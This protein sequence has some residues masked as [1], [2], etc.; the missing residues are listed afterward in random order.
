VADGGRV[1][2][3]RYA[4]D[5]TNKYVYIDAYRDSSAA[6]YTMAVIDEITRRQAGAGENAG[7]WALPEGIDLRGSAHQLQV[8]GE[9]GESDRFG[10]GQQAAAAVGALALYTSLTAAEQGAALVIPGPEVVL[11]K[12]FAKVKGFKFIKGAGRWVMQKVVRRGGAE[13]VEAVAESEAKALYQEFKA[14]RANA[15][16][17]EGTAKTRQRN[18]LRRQYMGQNPKTNSPTYRSVVERMRAAGKIV[19]EGADAKVLASDGTWIPLDEADLSHTKDAMKY[20]NETGKYWGERHPKVREFMLD[21]GN[22]VLDKPGPNRSAGA[23][24]KGAGYDPPAPRP[25]GPP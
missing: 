12:A 2:D 15:S 1:V 18:G 5:Y 19:G 4:I 3:D 17:P 25:G 22:Y 10:A 11:F 7:L 9:A 13:A 16:A 23:K 8:P 21:P 24:L 20:W 6:E 14:A